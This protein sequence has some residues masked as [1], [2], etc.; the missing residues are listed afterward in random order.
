MSDYYLSEIDR[1]NRENDKLRKEVERMKKAL[2]TIQGLAESE[3][4][5]QVAQEGLV[6]DNQELDK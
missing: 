2:E 4:I 6:P 1:I 3:Y 5:V